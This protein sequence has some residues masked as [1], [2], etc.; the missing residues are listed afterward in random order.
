MAV[1][2]KGLVAVSLPGNLLLIPHSPTQ[3]LPRGLGAAADSG[4]HG[5]SGVLA[6]GQEYMAPDSTLGT[7]VYPVALLWQPKL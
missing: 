5:G 1:C 2:L 3:P 4:T 7:Y 6:R